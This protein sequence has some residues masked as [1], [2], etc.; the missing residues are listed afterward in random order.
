[1]RYQEAF[2]VVNAALIKHNISFPVTENIL[3]ESFEDIIEEIGLTVVRKRDSETFSENGTKEYKFTKINVSDQIFRVQIGTG[4]QVPFTSKKDAPI[5]DDD[6]LANNSC[7]LDQEVSKGTITVATSA[8]P[9]QITSTAHGL[10]SDDFVKISEIV[11]LL[12]ATGALSAVNGIVHQ[13][14]RVDADNF[15]IDIDGSAYAVAYSSGGRWNEKTKKL[16]FSKTPDSGDDIVVSY[17][18]KPEPYYSILSEI[19]LPDNK[20]IFA[21]IY[22]VVARIMTLDGSLQLSSGYEGKANSQIERYFKMSRTREMIPDILPIY[23]QE[24]NEY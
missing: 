16:V 22:R 6:D 7:Y 11:G 13:I 8:K 14:T 10:V 5:E 18:A 19:D 20:L 2:E 21:A 1:M 17:Y 23:Y 4:T 9:I 24:F 12:S 3:I 15:T